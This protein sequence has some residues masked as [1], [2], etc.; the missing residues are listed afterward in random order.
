MIKQNVIQ[1]NLSL[2]FLYFV[3]AFLYLKQSLVE[4]MFMQHIKY[5]G[6]SSSIFK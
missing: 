2:W 5:F 3:I 1:V 4:I 6:C